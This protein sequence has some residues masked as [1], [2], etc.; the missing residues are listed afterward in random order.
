M[1]IDKLE[2]GALKHL[3]GKLRVDLVPPEAIEAIANAFTYGAMKYNDNSWRPGIPFTTIYASTLRHM[4]LWA[5]GED[6]DT[7]SNLSHIDHAI[8]N[9]AMLATHIKHN[10]EDLDDRESSTAYCYKGNGDEP[11]GAVSDTATRVCSGTV[12]NSYG[13][14]RNCS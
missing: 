5:K 12:R 8:C 4:L 3:E 9:L 10:R 2:T 13:Y 6:L 1:K 7:E 14:P 11:I